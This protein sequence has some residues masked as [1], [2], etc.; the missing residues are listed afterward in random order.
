MSFANPQPFSN[1]SPAVRWEYRPL[2]SEAMELRE[3]VEK[4][5][6]PNVVRESEFRESQIIHL[7]RAAADHALEFYGILVSPSVFRKT[8]AFLESLPEELQ[9]PIVV[10]ESNDEIGLDW[11]EGPERVVSL[12]IDSSNQ[13]GF[14]TLLKGKPPYGTVDYVHGISNPLPEILRSLLEHVYPLTLG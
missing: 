11:D 5:F 12:T 10:V 4:A 3:A 14:V 9:L 8:R 6:A 1:Y 7:L 2:G 13:I